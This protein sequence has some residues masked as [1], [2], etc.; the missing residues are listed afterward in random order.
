[1]R[2]CGYKTEEASARE[3]EIYVTDHMIVGLTLSEQL[4]QCFDTW[5]HPS[6]QDPLDLRT[7]GSKKLH[8]ADHDEALTWEVEFHLL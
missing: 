2:F 6:G 1:M 8:R 3:T 5:D 4:A 7:R